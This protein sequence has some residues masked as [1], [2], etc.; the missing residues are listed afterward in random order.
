MVSKA[1]RA[2]QRRRTTHDERTRPAFE[3][4]LLPIPLLRSLLITKLLA[5]HLVAIQ[6]MMT[7]SP[8]VVVAVASSFDCCIAFGIKQTLGRYFA[9]RLEQFPRDL[10]TLT[11]EPRLGSKDCNEQ[12]NL[13]DSHGSI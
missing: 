9:F 6:L 8:V 12:Y 10:T 1:A 7:S 11:L 13:H 3:L 2:G 4:L 5:S